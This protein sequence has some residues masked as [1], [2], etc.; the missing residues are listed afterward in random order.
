MMDGRIASRH[1]APNLRDFDATGYPRLTEALV[2][3]GLPPATIRK[4]LGENWLRLLDAVTRRLGRCGRH[5]SSEV[6]P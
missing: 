4:I 2:A 1:G 5:R 3:K 6:R